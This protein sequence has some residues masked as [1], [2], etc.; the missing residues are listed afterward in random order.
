MEPL[1]NP[2]ENNVFIDCVEVLKLDRVL[3]FNDDGR[4]P[5]MLSR[6]ASIRGNTVICTKP[7]DELPRQM[8][9]PRIAGGFRVLDNAGA[10]DKRRL[11]HG[12]P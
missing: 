10:G 4:A 12:K 5:G 7:S 3:K 2:V 8:F 6:M 11:N 9:D 1:Y